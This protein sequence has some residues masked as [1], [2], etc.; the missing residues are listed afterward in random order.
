[1]IPHKSKSK[2]ASYYKV[3]LSQF[4]IAPYNI[5]SEMIILS[6]KDTHMEN[7]PSNKT[8]ALTKSMNVDILVVGTLNQLFLRSSYTRSLVVSDL[9]LETKGFWFESGC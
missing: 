8:H 2:I 6:I 9:S 1:M 4:I 3:Y 7:T 5:K